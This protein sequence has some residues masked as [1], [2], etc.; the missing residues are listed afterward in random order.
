MTAVPES[1]RGRYSKEDLQEAFERKVLAPGI[2]NV[3]IESAERQVS[4]KG[5]YMIKTVV[6]PL[7]E[8]GVVESASTNVKLTTFVLLPFENDDA[9][10][11]LPANYQENIKR[12]MGEAPKTMRALFGEDEVPF[13]PR[14]D[15]KTKKFKFNGET[16]DNSAVDAAKKKVVDTAMEKAADLWEEPESIV[17]NV[18]YASVKLDDNSGSIWPAVNRLFGA[19]P[20]KAKVQDPGDWFVGEGQAAELLAEARAKRQR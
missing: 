11:E 1:L 17:G 5:Y 19:L 6:R 15:P 9:D 13:F 20:Q 18:L 10:L 4:K 16:I 12:W 14:Q 3:V 2:Y 8:E 7:E